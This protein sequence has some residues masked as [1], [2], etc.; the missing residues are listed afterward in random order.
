MKRES[1]KTHL[2]PHHQHHQR[3]QQRNKTK[4]LPYQL[5]RAPPGPPSSGRRR[6]TR[7]ISR[8]VRTRCP[9]SALPLYTQKSRANAPQPARKPTYRVNHHKS[10]TR[11]KCQLPRPSLSCARRKRRVRDAA[12]NRSLQTRRRLVQLMRRPFFPGAGSRWRVARDFN[13]KNGRDLIAAAQI[14][15][16]YATRGGR[17]C[18]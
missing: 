16:Q 11:R 18:A 2:Q 13:L 5:H 9:I 7:K 17:Y 1:S 10:Y 12:P 4:H 15:L 14:F 3:H 6:K 8:V